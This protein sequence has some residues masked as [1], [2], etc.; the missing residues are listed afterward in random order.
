LNKFLTLNDA[1][2]ALEIASYWGS[3]ST[4]NPLPWEQFPEIAPVLGAYS[5]AYVDN[6]IFSDYGQRGISPFVRNRLNSE[7]QI[8]S[9]NALYLS[10]FVLA[11]C[12]EQ[13]QRYCAAYVAKYNPAENYS[14][15]E[16]GLDTERNSGTDSD[17]QS[18]TDY[19][20]T[21]KYGHA[22]KSS[23]ESGLYGFDS[24]SAVNADTSVNV[25]TYE[26]TDKDGNTLPGD[27]RE[28]SGSRTDSTTHGHVKTLEHS[29]TRAGNIG[30]KTAAEML[31]DD[32]D[33]WVKTNLWA[34]VAR[35]TAQLLTIPIYE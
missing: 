25:T 9:T 7:N 34:M 8:D 6:L 28:I 4:Y 14:M 12:Y 18:Y 17:T 5:M 27:T 30:V 16:T 23:G 10:R 21:N 19:K 3:D 29:F 32:I 35:D 1:F 20:E 11:T 33:L 22:V 2:P 26:Q 31:R 15:T 24:D 13:W